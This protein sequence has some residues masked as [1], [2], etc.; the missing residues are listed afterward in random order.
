MVN[1]TCRVFST[2]RNVEDSGFSSS[3]YCPIA[4]PPEPHIASNCSCMAA[5]S[6]QGRAEQ[7]TVACERLCAIL[8]TDGRSRMIVQR[9]SAFWARL[10][11]SL[12][13]QP[14]PPILGFPRGHRQLERQR[15]RRTQDSHRVVSNRSPERLPRMGRLL[16]RAPSFRSKA[17]CGIVPFSLRIPMRRSEP[18]RST[19]SRS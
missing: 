19:P 1:L 10:R 9:V 6:W 15:I 13:R 7:R 17:N 3:Y 12:H 4:I 16:K 11:D 5:R 18:P 2:S 8:D 14:V